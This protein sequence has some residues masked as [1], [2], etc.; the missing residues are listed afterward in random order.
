MKTAILSTILILSISSCHS[1]FY[2][3]PFYPNK[4]FYPVNPAPY[5][6]MPLSEFLANSKHD[7]LFERNTAVLSKS[8]VGI[9][10]RKGKFEIYEVWYRKPYSL[11]SFYFFND[12]LYKVEGKSTE[13]NL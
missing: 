1:F 11:K 2:H 4:P 13:G 9:Q 3:Q 8:W 10:D 7:G 5:I 12:K 6:G